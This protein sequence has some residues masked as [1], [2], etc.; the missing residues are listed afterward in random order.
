M[1][2]LIVLGAA[3]AGGCWL[4]VDRWHG[5]GYATL[6]WTIDGRTDAVACRERGADRTKIRTIDSWNDTED[7]T[8]APCDA[9]EET[10]FI[11]RG[12]YR[13]EIT[14]LIRAARRS[15]HADQQD[16]P[17]RRARIDLGRR[18]RLSGMPRN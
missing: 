11:H 18:G 13:A 1:I 4:E 16:I 10:I 14:L 5:G 9:F 2:L 15:G 12:W 3:L 8:I 6:R 17:C 7:I